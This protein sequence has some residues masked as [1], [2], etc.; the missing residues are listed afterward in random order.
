MNMGE[1]KTLVLVYEH[2]VGNE[3]VAKP[4]EEIVALWK[5]DRKIKIIG[6]QICVHISD[7][8]LANVSACAELSLE[9]RM[10]IDLYIPG[11]KSE[12]CRVINHMFLFQQVLTNGAHHTPRPNIVMF[13]KGDYITLEKDSTIHLID[14]ADYAGHTGSTWAIVYYL[15]G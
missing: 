5:T 9:P 4:D 3:F 12:S 1:I 6:S 10:T 8:P 14:K 15:E 11:E 13:P 7:D 2:S